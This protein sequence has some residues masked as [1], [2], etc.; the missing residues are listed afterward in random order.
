MI[1]KNNKLW[2]PYQRDYWT[3]Q[4][5]G[6]IYSID[7]KIDADKWVSVKYSPLLSYILQHTPKNAK[8]LEAGCGMGQWVIYLANLGYNIVGLDFV[9]PTIKKA[10]E[11]H[12]HLQFIIGDVTNFPFIDMSF[13][14]ILSWGV[15]EH[16][17]SGPN[18]ALTEAFRILTKD[19]I[20][21]IT[22]PCKNYLQLFFSPWLYLKRKIAKNKLVMRIRKK[23]P[24]KETFFQ[25]SFTKNLFKQYVTDAGF[26]VKNII[27][28]SHETGFVNAANSLLRLGKET[29]IFHK[30]KAEKWNGLTAIGNKICKFLKKSNSSAFARE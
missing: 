18:K 24:T 10:K 16:F 19:G 4:W 30:N 22:V 27:P 12:P 5:E 29:K 26:E 3:G 20:L 15:V 7:D 23:T 17:E 13:D 8:I 9:E 1:S 14:A 2:E 28:I 11:N 25:Y 21:Y 6:S